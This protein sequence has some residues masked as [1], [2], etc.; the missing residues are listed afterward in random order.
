MDFL[1]SE[2]GRILESLLNV[3]RFEIRVVGQYLFP[4]RSVSDLANDIGNRDPHAPDAGTTAHDLGIEGY[5]VKH[6]SPFYRG[7]RTSPNG[8]VRRREFA[9]LVLTGSDVSPLSI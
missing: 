9:V 2:P 7:P 6:D 1:P 3:L 8:Q 5:A 4:G